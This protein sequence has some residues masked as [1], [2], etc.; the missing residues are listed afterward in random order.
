MAVTDY[1]PGDWVWV[2]A[3]DRMC[4]QL[5]R[6]SRSSTGGPGFVMDR[7]WPAGPNARRTNTKWIQRRATPEEI[8]AHQ[9]TQAGGL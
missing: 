2:E 9:L 7:P 1:K 8:A 4:V 6:P 3:G 5:L